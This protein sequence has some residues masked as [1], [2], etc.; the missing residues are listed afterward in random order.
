[1]NR[2]RFLILL[3]VVLIINSCKQDPDIT[4]FKIT[5]SV[6]NLDST[7]VYLEQNSTKLD[8]SI[9]KDGK[10]SLS[11]RM[12]NK[13]PCEIVFKS[14]KPSKIAP[15]SQGWMHFITTFVEHGA[16]YKISALSAEDIL[17]HKY[18]LETDA[19][20]ANQYYKYDI[21]FFEQLRN[22]KNQKKEFSAKLKDA[23]NSNE[24]IL[25]EKLSD[26]LNKIHDKLYNLNLD[27][28]HQLIQKLPN[29]YPAVYLLSKAPDISTNTA[30][31]IGIEKKLTEE[32][33]EHYYGKKFIKILSKLRTDLPIQIKLDAVDAKNKSFNFNDFK[34]HKFMILDFWATWCAPCLDEMPAALEFEQKF[35]D[36]KVAYVFL[37][38]DSRIKTWQKQSSALGL[39]HNYRIKHSAKPY[40][41]ETLNM[42]QI[43]RYVV[44]NNMG[45]VL[46]KY[47]PSPSDPKFP[48]LIDSLLAVSK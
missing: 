6:K 45:N 3:S 31:Y 39:T 30:F 9:I 34:N 33:R 44:I 28:Q 7:K 35:N 42:G 1:M 15:L 19:V 14:N 48:K 12:W 26:S 36:K 23:E 17:N 27:S 38:Y 29:S 40:L 5:G 24:E 22:L 16:S 10:F 20:S 25:Y 4:N 21:E 46:V 37:S 2:F 47:A 41:M 43:P 11:A 32:Y 8:S 13:R 18:S